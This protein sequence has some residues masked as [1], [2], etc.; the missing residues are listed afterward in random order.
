MTKYLINRL[1]Y[2]IPVIIGVSILVFSMLHLVPG[3]PVRAMFADAG[4]ASAEQIEQIRRLLGLDQPL[5]IQYLN[6]IGKVLRGDLGESIISKQSV[7]ELIVQ[8]FPSTLQLTIAGLGLAIVIGLLMGIIAALKHN[9][10]IDNLTM[11]IS[12]LGVSMP[13]FWL[14]LILIYV[15]AIQLRWVPIT[16]GSDLSRLALPAIAL[17]FQASAIIARLVRSNMLE[18][19]QED[20]IR[21]ARAKGL[22]AHAVA[23][24]HALRNALIPVVTVVGL[25][26]GGLLGGAVIIETVFAR[27]G[28][29][30]LLVG[31]LQ[32]RDFPIAQSAV[33]MIALVYVF[34]NLGVDLLYGWIDPRIHYE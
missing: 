10:W 18:V 1:L 34:V 6:Y 5:P 32:A 3:D 9:S 24:R 21:T 31:A 25:Q 33:L 8:N 13:S 30:R 11:F 26:F 14:G 15:F 23:A 7:W 12:T 20:Y 19:L 17:G 28:I 29:G 4:G 16:S 2:T 22:T 27:Q